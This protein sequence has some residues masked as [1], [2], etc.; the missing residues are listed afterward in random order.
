MTT[1][2]SVHVFFTPD[3][4]DEMA[5]RGKTV[6][7]IDVLRASTTIAVALRNGAREIIPVT[8]VESAVKLSGN[9][10]GEVILLGG[11]RNGKPIEGFHLGN[12]PSEYTE[13]RVTGKSIIFSTTNG[14][15]AMVRARH[16]REML[17]CSFVNLS[18]V[19]EPLRRQ[20]R[21]VMIVC[22]G[23]NGVFSLEDAVCAGMLVQKLSEGPGPAPGLSDAALGAQTLARAFGR[24]ILKMLRTSEHG[25]YLA[26]IGLGDDLAFCAGLDT[27]PVLP[28]LSGSVVKLRRE[29]E[30]AGRVGQTVAS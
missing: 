3:Q 16:S 5:L 18:A 27:V 8:T 20:P 22:A 29:A 25:R 19:A 2:P 13:E 17:V 21:D 9:L 23:N 11:E 15:Q 4:T 14:S 30:T 6:V 24:N 26:G 1:P 7:M 12:S 28:E 10:F